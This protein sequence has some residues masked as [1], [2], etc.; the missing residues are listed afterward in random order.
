[1]LSH[2]R[3]EFFDIDKGSPAPIAHEALERIAAL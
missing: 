2:R 1:L 3:R